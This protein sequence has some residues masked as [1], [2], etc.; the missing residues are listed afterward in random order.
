VLVLAIVWY[1]GD[2]DDVWHAGA[3]LRC[4][5]DAVVFALMLLLALLIA[6]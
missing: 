6:C 1:G 4:S 3:V 2:T 5:G